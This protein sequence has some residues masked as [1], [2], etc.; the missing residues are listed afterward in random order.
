[1]S[2]YDINAIQS[3]MATIKKSYKSNAT[4]IPKRDLEALQ[5]ALNKEFSDAHC[6]EVFYSYNPDKLFFGMCVVP[7][8]S[9]DNCAMIIASDNPFRI[10]SYSIEIDSKLLDPILNLSPEELTA[11]VLHEIGHLVNNA[12]PVEEIRK[13][14]DVYIAKHGNIPIDAITPKNPACEF[15]QFGITDALRKQVS[16]FENPNKEEIL[17]DEYVI[18]NGYG[19][20]LINAFKKISRHTVQLNKQHNNKFVALVWAFRISKNFTE[21]RIA[22]HH[23]INKLEKSTG[24]LIIKRQLTGLNRACKGSPMYAYTEGSGSTFQNKLAAAKYKY[25]YDVLRK[26]EDDYYEFA[27]RLKSVTAEDDVLRL[28]R[29]VNIRINVVEEFLN[30]E[31]SDSDK[32]RFLKLQDKLIDLREEISKKN[33]TKDRML[34]LWVEYPDIVPNRY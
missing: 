32:Q 25:K 24:S 12:T 14:I 5:N 30:S 29:D 22:A 31:L 3:A 28:L 8:L 16:M 23:T 11:V 27:I 15:L 4:Q 20:H 2:Q 6:R 18:R 17:A 33:I 10:Q 13:D 1:M 26:Y 19:D 34:G 9:A 7:H 21:R